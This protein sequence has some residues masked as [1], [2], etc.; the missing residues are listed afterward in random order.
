MTKKTRTKKTLSILS[1]LTGTF[2]IIIG[3]P[4]IIFLVG[5]GLILF[6]CGLISI[7]IKLWKGEEMW[8]KKK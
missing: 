5:I 3:I 7:G 2:F 4:L 8:F 6:G 1:I